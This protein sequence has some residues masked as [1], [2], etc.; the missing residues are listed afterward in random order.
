M[1]GSIFSDPPKDAYAATLKTYSTI[2][3]LKTHYNING[4]PRMVEVPISIMPDQGVATSTSASYLPAP[5]LDPRYELVQVRI[6]YDRERDT[7][8]FHV[9]GYDYKYMVT[10]PALELLGE[11]GHMEIAR[12]CVREAVRIGPLVKE[13]EPIKPDRTGSIYQPDDEIGF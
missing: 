5:L 8:L 10:R 1:A 4:L 13:P 12:Q 7:V 9:A 3:G 6:E 11:K 2:E